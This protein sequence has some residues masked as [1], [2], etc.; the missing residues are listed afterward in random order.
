VV[1]T[2]GKELDR[3]H[4]C[5]V[6]LSLLIQFVPATLTKAIC[7]V[8]IAMKA[9]WSLP[10]LPATD[11]VHR[12]YRDIKFSKDK[13]PYKTNFAASLSRTGRKSS[14]AMYYIHVQV[15]GYLQIELERKLLHS[16]R[17]TSSTARG[18]DNDRSRML[19]A[20]S[21]RYRHH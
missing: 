13:T 2:C 16:Y 8:P 3:V 1:P 11:L 12:I 18:K 21:S 20:L 15:S 4:Q 6:R 19:G 10:A 14:F 17:T 7:R 9:D 5:S